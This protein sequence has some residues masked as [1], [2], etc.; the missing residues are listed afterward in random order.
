[1]R[2]AS[3]D[4]GT[5]EALAYEGEPTEY[6]DDTLA[7]DDSSYEAAESTET[8]CYDAGSEASEVSEASEAYEGEELSG[9]EPGV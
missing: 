7:A 5:G 9:E 6:A 4:D 1:V 2:D 3:V 8:G